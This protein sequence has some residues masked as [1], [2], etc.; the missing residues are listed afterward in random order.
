[1]VGGCEAHEILELHHGEGGI[2]H[3]VSDDEPGLR[4]G[5]E[6][7]SRFFRVDRAARPDLVADH[8]ELLRLRALSKPKP[9]ERAR[10]AELLA[11]LEPYAV[12][13]SEA[14]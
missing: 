7:L 13:E 12:R 8:R 10:L 11:K 1:V 6:L 9:N 3:T 14:S 5:S 4:T 2:V